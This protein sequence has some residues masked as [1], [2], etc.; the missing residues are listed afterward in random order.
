VRDPFQRISYHGW[1][2]CISI[3][4]PSIRAIVTADVGPRIIHLEFAGSLENLFYERSEDIGNSNGNRF[5]M[6]GGHRFWIAPEN[7]RTTL[8]D[9]HPVEVTTIDNGVQFT[10]VVGSLKKIIEMRFTDSDD[11]L[12]LT[13]RVTNVGREVTLLAPWALTVMRP[14]GTAFL[15]LPPAAPW[16]P[17]H[18]LPVSSI[19]LWSYSDLSASC[20][21][22]GPEFIRLEQSLVSASRFGMQKI[23]VRNPSG[24]AGYYRSGVLFVKKMKWQE[25][26]YPDLG[27]NIECFSSGEFLELETLAPLIHLSPNN[28]SEL[29]ESWILLNNVAQH[30]IAA[31]LKDSVAALQTKV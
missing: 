23:G 22:L 18:L 25:G 6:Y 24:W 13:H 16:G 5:R 29:H 4:T 11:R 1:Q 27:C 20:W 17:E 8:P 14:G 26:V 12:E 19:A 30:E 9:N 15:P 31:A 28:S 7:E 21:S 10:T 2:N 3:S